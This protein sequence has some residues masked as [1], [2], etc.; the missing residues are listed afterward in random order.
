MKHRAWWLSRGFLPFFV[1]LFTAVTGAS[2]ALAQEEKGGSGFLGGFTASGKVEV[3]GTS[4]EKDRN[5]SKYEE[6]RH[7]PD[8]YPV[9]GEIKLDLDNRDRNYYIEFRADDGLQDDQSYLLRLGKYGKYEV[10]LEWDELPRAFTNTARS[11]QVWQGDGVFAVSDDVQTALQGNALLIDELLTGAGPVRA[12]GGRDTGRFSFRYTPAPAWDLRV[13]YEVRSDDAMRPL[14]TTFFFT[15]MIE[16]L[17]PI[18]YLTHDVTASL[19][20]GNR[21]WSLR[22]AYA[23]SV[24]ENDEDVVVWDNPFRLDDIVS[25]PSPR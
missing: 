14:G 20:Y 24:F 23:G 12:R 10:E 22:L 15:N 4:V 11:L 7:I 19:E 1:L 3:L 21:D 5:S 13:G 9:V 6:Y 25:G 2:V 18:D 16:I 8:D 17:N